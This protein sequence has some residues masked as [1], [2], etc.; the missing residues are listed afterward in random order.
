MTID[1]GPVICYLAPG[2]SLPPQ[3]TRT[4][5]LPSLSTSYGISGA[6]CGARLRNS[7]GQGCGPYGSRSRTVP[8]KT[9]GLPSPHHPSQRSSLAPASGYR[10]AATGA[11][12]GI[13]VEGTALSSSPLASGH[14]NASRMLFN[15]GNVGPFNGTNRAYALSVRCVQ[16]SAGPL[17]SGGKPNMRKYG[18]RHGRFPV[19][20]WLLSGYFLPAGSVLNVAW[21]PSKIARPMRAGTL[22]L[23]MTPN[24]RAGA[25]PRGGPQACSAGSDPKI[26]TDIPFSGPDIQKRSYF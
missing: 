18:S 10:H 13:G 15:A 4:D 20:S 1:N 22:P 25:S 17:F 11:L 8:C 7:A 6:V 23:T 14:N 9:I 26:R 12:G 2:N 3:P 5:D 21:Q 19:V 16:A 24:M